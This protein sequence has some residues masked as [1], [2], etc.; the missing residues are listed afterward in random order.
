MVDGRNACFIHSSTARNDEN[1]GLAQTAAMRLQKLAE[2][3]LA[4][5]NVTLN[6]GESGATLRTCA[7]WIYLFG[8]GSDVVIYIVVLVSTS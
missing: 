4:G 3:R 5:T 2:T 8:G 1:W 7:A 6:H